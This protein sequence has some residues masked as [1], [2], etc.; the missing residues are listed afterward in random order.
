MTSKTP[1][2]KSWKS[3]LRAMYPE[4][5]EGDEDFED[6][7]YYFPT[8]KSWLE[9]EEE[10]KRIDTLSDQFQKIRLTFNTDDEFESFRVRAI[11]NNT[12]LQ[13]YLEDKDIAD[14]AKYL[15]GMNEYDVGAKKIVYYF[16]DVIKR[17]D[18]QKE[19]KKIRKSYD[20]PETGY[21]FTKED[22]D[23]LN[24]KG[25]DIAGLDEKINELSIKFG[26]YSFVWYDILRKYIFFNRIDFRGR[27]YSYSVFKLCKVVD[28]KQK[29]KISLSPADWGY[30]TEEDI[31][32]YRETEDYLKNREDEEFPIS[33]RISP[34][35]SERDILSFIRRN[36]SDISR[37]QKR[38]NLK[39]I[40]IGKV[41][42][43]NSFIKERNDLIYEN[44]RLPRI[45]IMR[46]LTDKY[47][48]DRTLDYA[49][50]GK[51]ISLETKKRKEV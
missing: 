43:K 37:L 4:G 35:A 38:Y 29:H 46:L 42:K 28:E 3:E 50:I 32:Q 10:S 18:F 20:M 14:F 9:M 8:K 31:K 16:N 5:K 11:K 51:I 23:L 30:E 45:E 6:M 40:G 1:S 27:I 36:F 2:K 7:Y 26:L 24:E 41:K 47:G 33:L 21:I 39:H 25:S 49:Y 22:N 34:Y 48:A 13:D 15:K 19:I 12:L 44:R 17:G